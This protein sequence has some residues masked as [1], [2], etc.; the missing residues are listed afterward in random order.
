VPNAAAP[1]TQTPPSINSPLPAQRVGAPTGR[2]GAA[3]SVDA[4]YRALF[5]TLFA[6]SAEGV[7]VCGAG[8]LIRACNTPAAALLGAVPRALVGQPWHHHLAQPANETGAPRE[9]EAMIVNAQPPRSVTLRVTSLGPAAGGGW[10]ILLHDNREDLATTQKLEQLANFDSLTGL[11]NRSLFRDSLNAAMERAKRGQKTLALMFL[12]LDRFKLINDDLGHA[13]GDRVL[14]HVASTLRNCLRGADSVLRSG[15]ESFTLSRLGGD[16][17]TVIADDIRAADNAAHIAQRIL[18]ALAEPLQVDG[19]ELVISAS[20]GIA[21]Y[22]IDDVDIDGLIRHADMAMYRSKAA[23]RNAYSFFSEELNAANG[24]R[25]SLESSLRRAI[26]RHEFQLH[27][28]PKADLK[29]GRIVGVEALLRWNRP[30]HG[31]VAPDRFIG[32]LEETGMIMPVGAWVIRTSVAQMAEWDRC[33]LPPLRVSFNL[34]ARQFRHQYIA[35][36]IEDSL[37]EHA[38]DPRRYEI[39]LTESL[40]MED[41]ETNRALLENFRRMGVGLAIDDFGTG[42][43]SLAYLKRFA[44]DT[45]K[46]DRSFV[47]SLPQ[48]SEDMAIATAI[49]A[50]GRSMQ[51]RIVAEGVETEEQ[52]QAL[53]GLGCDEI[54]GYLLSRPLSAT[55]FALWLEDRQR[56]GRSKRRAYGAVRDAGPVTVFSVP[57]DM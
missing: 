1:S 55:D 11:A 8:G 51:M 23:G 5:E 22:P 4:E 25:I 24:A 15:A 57:T 42:H 39:E 32:V 20:I 26:E 17:F 16:E 33:G 50:L 53:R 54:Q 12:D 27:Y 52:A 3:A 9:G 10:L 43:S 36:L 34:S 47:Q 14:K 35:S 37:R 49:V 28:Q 31:M 6:A 48:S 21:L 13:V 29:T 19:E 18:D 7:L 46:I 56:S 2:P 44:I 45:L 41:T 38:I 40:L 30:E